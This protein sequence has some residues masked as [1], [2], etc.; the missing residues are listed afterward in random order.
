MASVWGSPVSKP[1]L[2]PRVLWLADEIPQSAY[3]GGILLNRLF[4]GYPVDRLLVVGRQPNS[5]AELLP[6]RYER[7]PLLWER[8]TRTRFARMARTLHALGL[9]PAFASSPGRLVRDFQPDV[10]VTLMQTFPYFRAAAQFARSHGLPLVS[11]VHDLPGQFD[12]VY[13]FARR[14][15]EARIAAIYRQS[16]RRLCISPEMAVRLEQKYRVSGEVLYPNRSETVVPRPLEDSR[17]WRDPKVF[18]IGY[19]GSIS[20][21]YGE[22]LEQ[23]CS[24]LSELGFRLYYYGHEDRTYLVRFSPNTVVQR[25]FARTPE[26]T[27]QRVQDE[28]DTVILPYSFARAHHELYSTHFPSKLPEYLALRMPV[29]VLGPAHATGV[30]W[31]LRNPG[32]VLAITEPDPPAW[33]SALRELASSVQL[34]L[35]LAGEAWLAA[36]RDFSPAALKSFFLAVIEDAHLRSLQR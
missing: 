16:V 3:A 1:L 15:Q 13:P 6:V 36:E 32:A 14:M 12:A 22:T 19:A 31:A 2:L 18:T 25:G 11:L 5:D 23:L 30:R 28:C 33:F 35:R 21:G 4:S 27:W 17:A 20:Y 26:A 8:L 9:L 24:G 34:R 29:V 7:L 10:V